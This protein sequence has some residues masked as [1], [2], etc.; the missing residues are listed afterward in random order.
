[1]G[2]RAE[3]IDR[4]RDDVRLLGELV[5]DVLREQ[6]GNDL[7]GAVEHVRT[8]AIALRSAPAADDQPLL[9][10]A[11]QQSTAR[12]MQLVRAFSAY[13]HLINLAEQHH[14]V[15]TLR[16]RQRERAAP[17]HESIAAAFIELAA[18]GVEPAQLRAGVQHLEVHPVLTA[19]PSEARRR[20]LLHH[21]EAAAQLVD[22]LDRRPTPIERAALLDALRARVTLIWQTAE[23][24]VERPS[25]LDEVQSVVYVL[26]GTVYDVLPRVYRALDLASGEPGLADQCRLRFGSWVGGDRDGNPAVT[27]E[28]SRAAARLARAAVLRRYREERGVS[29]REIANQ[30]KIGTRYLEYIEGDRHD[31]LPAAVYLRGFLQEYARA[32]GLDPRRTAN[33]Y[34]AQFPRPWP[35]D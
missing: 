11:E 28:V 30:S 31:M 10:W 14:R 29:L 19:H 1:V 24:R 15:R 21:I 4:L 18:D 23:A 25:V 3:P 32:L 26:A 7:F 35:Q 17:L 20:T 6:G 9:A 2:V 33:A 22:Q 16:E 12:L 34:M 8:A 27:P 13:F 5:G